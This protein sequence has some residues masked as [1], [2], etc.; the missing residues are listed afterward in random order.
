MSR[1]EEKALAYDAIVGTDLGIPQE[2]KAERFDRRVVKH[3]AK[4]AGRPSIIVP[5]LSWHKTEN[6]E[7]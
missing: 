6:G 3:R 4:N 1:E 7:G 2:Q 5:E